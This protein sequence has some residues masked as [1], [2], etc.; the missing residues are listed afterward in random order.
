[1]LILSLAYHVDQFN[2]SQNGLCPPKR[3]ESQHWAYSAFD[4]SVLLLDL[5]VQI[6]ALP[7]ANRFL[8]R[9]VGVE[10]CQCCCVSATFIDSDH[11]W[12]AVMA[13]RLAKEA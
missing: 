3:F 12:F 2:A 11:L 6:L 8:I 5:V 10:R 1:M 4:I 7:D 9:F 13:N